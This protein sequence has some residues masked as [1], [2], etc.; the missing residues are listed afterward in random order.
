[1]AKRNFMQTPEQRERANYYSKKR[2]KKV[3]DLPIMQEQMVEEQFIETPEVVEQEPVFQYATPNMPSAQ[4][5]AVTFDRGTAGIWAN[6]VDNITG[7]IMS[8]T[9]DAFEFNAI[10][11]KQKTKLAIQEYVDSSAEIDRI[12]EE[13]NQSF[14][15][16]AEGENIP[17]MNIPQAVQQE[18]D[19]SILELSK[20]IYIQNNGSEELSSGIQEE[21]LARGI[22]EP[23]DQ[24]SKQQQLDIMETIFIQSDSLLFGDSVR[25][26]RKEQWLNITEAVNSKDFN[27][28]A[29]NAAKYRE[30]LDQSLLNQKGVAN[31]EFV[32]GLFKGVFTE[33]NL[34][35]EVVKQ[36]VGGDIERL[37]NLQTESGTPVFNITE[38]EKGNVVSIG[39]NGS[40]D[41]FM[42]DEKTKA[43][44]SL[45]FAQQLRSQFP[46]NNIEYLPKEITQ[47]LRSLAQGDD[48]DPFSIT[49]LV[50]LSSFNEDSIDGLISRNREIG[51]IG[52]DTSDQQRLMTLISLHKYMGTDEPG[53]NKDIQLTLNTFDDIWN[54]ETFN[55]AQS[56]LFSAATDKNTIS[57]RNE[58]IN[59]FR[60]RMGVSDSEY[61]P[62]AYDFEVEDNPSLASLMVLLNQIDKRANLPEK[63]RNALKN[64]IYNNAR[65][66]PI[67]REID[68]KQK[69]VDVQLR[70]KVDYAIYQQGVRTFD[71]RINF[72]FRASQQN[73]S[74]TE[75]VSI[76][77]D[78]LSPNTY[79]GFDRDELEKAMIY[80]LEQMRQKE[81][82]Y[83][84]MNG[85]KPR[86][87]YKISPQAFNETVL[88]MTPSVQNDLFGLDSKNGVDSIENL[89]A[90]FDELVGGRQVTDIQY[91]NSSDISRRQRNNANYGA[92]A[93]GYGVKTI[94]Y[95]GEPIDVQDSFASRN[96]SGMVFPSVYS[97]LYV[98]KEGN[99]V[100]GNL[101]PLPK[102]VQRSLLSWLMGTTAAAV[103][104]SSKVIDSPSST[105][106]D[107]VR[108]GEEGAPDI[109][110]D[111][112][113]NPETYVP[114]DFDI[115][116]MA[117]YEWTTWTQDK[118]EKFDFV[119]EKSTPLIID[120]LTKNLRILADVSPESI[121]KAIDQVIDYAPE[122]Y[123]Q[124]ERAI[125]KDLG[126]AMAQS[127]IK[128]SQ[129][130]KDI[131]DAV[132]EAGS[133]LVT[134]P[135]QVIDSVKKS[136]SNLYK[137]IQRSPENEKL[138]AMS[139]DVENSSELNNHLKDILPKRELL[140]EETLTTLDQQQVLDSDELNAKQKNREE[141]TEYNKFEY[142]VSEKLRRSSLNL[143]D[144]LKINEMVETRSKFMSLYNRVKNTQQEQPTYLDLYEN[145]L[146]MRSLTL[147]ENN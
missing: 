13:I 139:E 38:D 86:A 63:E 35:I 33:T 141:Q 50:F 74:D 102:E 131:M 65:V 126:V 127:M 7:S 46:S 79:R 125:T 93:F 28:I 146:E 11:K 8:V 99:V 60:T 36:S 42:G 123:T 26:A 64:N 34:N 3:S 70:N 137:W 30:Q 130:P 66:V 18:R 61:D 119:V 80:S 122:A 47:G 118:L 10:R 85:K 110:Y 67:L 147:M 117:I 98:N 101:P 134:L 116:E 54:P 95:N 109:R 62:L 21:L 113:N 100:E 5:I 88:L 41:Q 120:A 106:L 14:I 22:E 129:A 75:D 76:I 115:F 39:F 114:I 84:Q 83:L 96:R 9:Q 57:A 128:L 68:G 53:K 31:E 142:Y 4:E 132:S 49:S 82:R 81:I 145:L 91:A 94:V 97:E 111:M 19:N 20:K 104:F 40:P 138:E 23:F 92:S 112:L 59:S 78:N 37:R 6:V 77:L 107:K 136:Y 32:Q 121:G 29:E 105:V 135:D 69:L 16:R 143:N 87:D 73:R 1:M 43:I 56:S 45:V 133:Q 124:V 72:E 12:T 140:T 144:Q 2:Q 58:I 90:N 44:A 15:G 51:G 103:E 48:S 17:R 25:A 24:L 55:A 27:K 108:S 52:L 71:E 89:M